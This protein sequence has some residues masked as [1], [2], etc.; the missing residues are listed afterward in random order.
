MVNMKEI[1]TFVGLHVRK[2]YQ[3]IQPGKKV[4]KP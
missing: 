4:E 1:D 2:N 3:V